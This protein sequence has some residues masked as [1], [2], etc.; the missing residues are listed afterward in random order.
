MEARAVRVLAH[1]PRIS[2]TYLFDGMRCEADKFGIPPRCTCVVA[3]NALADLHQC[4]LDVAWALVVAKVFGDLL[5]VK[6][7]AEPGVPPKKE[8]KQHDQ[9]RGEVK[10]KTRARGHAAGSFF[11]RRARGHG[12]VLR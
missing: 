9:P 10:K 1:H 6:L 12:G 11:R 7:A 5:I 3:H 4:V 8:G 2:V